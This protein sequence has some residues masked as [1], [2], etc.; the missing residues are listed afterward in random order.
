MASMAE[1]DVIIKLGGSAITEKTK[2]ET[3]KLTEINRA[4]QL[5][6]KCREHQLT[7]LVVH[8]AG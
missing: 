2:L 7:C 8:G 3:P 5:I 4:V 1:I 6:N